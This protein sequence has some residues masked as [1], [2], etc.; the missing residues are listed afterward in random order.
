M[1]VAE[2]KDFCDVECPY[3]GAALDVD[4]PVD[5]DD[6]GSMAREEDHEMACP[7]CDG[8]MVVHVVWD[9]GYYGAEVVER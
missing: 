5:F 2:R 4:D 7:V 6:G 3:C 8:S 9:P 1:R